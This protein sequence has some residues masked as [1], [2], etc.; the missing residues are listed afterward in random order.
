MINIDLTEEEATL[1]VEFQEYYETF[2]A[3]RNSGVFEVRNGTATLNFD[4]GGTVTD[5]D[6]S[7]KLY[8]Q[9][10]PVLVDLQVVK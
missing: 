5:I 1:F 4:A 6:C 10:M 8:K 9:G 2:T 3:L 7:F